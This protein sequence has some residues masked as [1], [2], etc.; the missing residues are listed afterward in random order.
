MQVADSEI[1]R[2]YL[3]KNVNKTHGPERSNPD[4]YH[5]KDGN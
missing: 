4:F 3:S 5:G 2:H 1:L